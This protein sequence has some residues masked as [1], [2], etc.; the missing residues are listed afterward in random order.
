MTNSD[1]FR[2]GVE[3]PFSGIYRVFHGQGHLQPHCVTLVAKK[4]FPRCSTCGGFVHYE[5]IF[6]A[7]WIGTHEMFR[8]DDAD[9][10]GSQLDS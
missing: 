4:F 7:P 8:F 1:S 9:Q 2:A 6:D 10:P 5:L 3:V